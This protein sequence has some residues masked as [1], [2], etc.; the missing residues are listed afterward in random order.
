MVALPL[1]YV[2]LVNKHCWRR[3]DPSVNGQIAIRLCFFLWTS[4]VDVGGTQ[5]SLVGLLLICFFLW[6]ST[7]DIG[8]TH[9]SMIRL[10]LFY[11][12]LVDQ[13]SW[14]WADPS[15]ND[16][17]ALRL[18]FSSGQALYPFGGPI[19]QWSDYHSSM[20]F[21]RTSTVDVVGTN[22]SI[23]RLPFVHVFLVD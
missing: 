5:Q 9:P 20:F 1:V 4:T 23:I 15:V 16:Q 2:F 17:I 6:T 14:R 11:V 13:H 10:P 8:W 18:C 21:L 22:P 7:V 19:R 12:F 3:A